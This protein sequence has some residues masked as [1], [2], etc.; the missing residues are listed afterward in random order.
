MKLKKKPSTHIFLLEY[1]IID[2]YLLIIIV[3]SLL[4]K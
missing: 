3:I 4:H 1:K 2:H